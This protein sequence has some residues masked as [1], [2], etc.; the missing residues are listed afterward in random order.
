MALN[1]LISVPLTGQGGPGALLRLNTCTT[2]LAGRA[3]L[4]LEQRSSAALAHERY[5]DER[6]ERPMMRA[7]W[8]GPSGWVGGSRESR[9]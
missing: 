7:R 5:T 3:S 9:S 2:S 4:R 1:A 6:I 8:D